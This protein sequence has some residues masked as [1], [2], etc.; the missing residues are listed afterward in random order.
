S[1]ELQMDKSIDEILRVRASEFQQ[2][3]ALT[4]MAAAE[5]GHSPAQAQQVLER[6]RQ[7]GFAQAVRQYSF[8][9]D[10]SFDRE[11][12]LRDPASGL[13]ELQ[14]LEHSIR[15]LPRTSP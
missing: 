3:L 13:N 9:Q 7:E 14:N 4:M 6:W 11:P 15:T 5:T 2:L 1:A 10:L 12:G 8:A